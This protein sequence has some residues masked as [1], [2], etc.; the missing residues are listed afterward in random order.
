MARLVHTIQIGGVTVWYWDEFTLP[1]ELAEDGSVAAPGVM[2]ESSQ[3]S[4]FADGVSCTIGPP[5]V[6]SDELLAIARSMIEQ[7]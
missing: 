6:P 2:V 1:E 5:E 4:W 7:R 3:V